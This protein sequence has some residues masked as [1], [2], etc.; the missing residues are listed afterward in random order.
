MLI[1]EFYYDP[2]ILKN[3]VIANTDEGFYVLREDGILH[4]TEKPPSSLKLNLFKER[5]LFKKKNHTLPHIDHLSEFHG[6]Y[7]SNLDTILFFK[8]GAVI[9][10]L[11][12]NFQ[13]AYS[14]YNSL[15]SSEANPVFYS[16]QEARQLGILEECIKNSPFYSQMDYKSAKF[17]E[18]I[19]MGFIVYPGWLLYNE[20]KLFSERYLKNRVLSVDFVMN[21]LSPK[22]NLLQF[23]QFWQIPSLFC[24]FTHA[25]FDHN[26]WNSYAKHEYLP[27]YNTHLFYLHNECIAEI[28]CVDTFLDPG[29]FPYHDSF[30]LTFNYL[31]EYESDV[32]KIIILLITRYDNIITVPP[33]LCGGYE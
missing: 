22:E 11:H 3:S 27:D 20:P 8:N 32:K 4:L 14:H 33:H 26:T 13:M 28:I 30:T 15:F 24:S 18:P 12:R 5:F 10:L 1:R 25:S 9:K 29:C 17:T 2:C 19:E 6:A 23:N 16:K 31:K 7:K 21:N